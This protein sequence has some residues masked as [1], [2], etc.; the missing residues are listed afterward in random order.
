MN[1]ILPLLRTSFIIFCPTSS[2]VDGAE[3]DRESSD[4]RENIR[5]KFLMEMPEDFYQFWEFCKSINLSKP[6]SKWVS[7]IH[8]LCAPVNMSYVCTFAGAIWYYDPQG[9]SHGTRPY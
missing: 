8:R 1:P 6:E 2:V 4:V 9:K 7:S 5:R 3:L